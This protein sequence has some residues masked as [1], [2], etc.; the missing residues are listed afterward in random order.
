MEEEDNAGGIIE[1]ELYDVA[2]FSD[3]GRREAH[4]LEEFA[5]HISQNSGMIPLS[6]RD[7]HSSSEEDDS[8]DEEE[9]E[10]P[11]RRRLRI[12]R[13][14]AGRALKDQPESESDSE[15]EDDGEVDDGEVENAEVENAEEENAEVENA[16]EENPE[17]ENE[18]VV[19]EPA[20][21]AG[22]QE[23]DEEDEGGE[24]NLTSLYAR[25]KGLVDTKD[26]VNTRRTNSQKQAAVWEVMKFAHIRQQKDLEELRALDFKA[27]EKLE[28]AETEKKPYCVCLLCYDDP[29]VSLYCSLVKPSYKKTG[30]PPYALNGNGNMTSHVQAKHAEVWEA[31]KA[32]KHNYKY[33]EGHAT[34]NFGERLV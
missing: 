20:A 34:G 6:A 7:E 31:M 25:A 29:A 5:D 19:E 24:T 9:E 3:E 11:Q 27:F 28:D 4:G 8:D 1:D 15:D 22:S 14:K 32:L 23:E 2:Q 10:E 17:V 18:P 33:E 16:E 12:A 21:A 26:K 13:R 30:G